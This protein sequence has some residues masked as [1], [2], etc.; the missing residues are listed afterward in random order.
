MAALAWLVFFGFAIPLA[1]TDARQHRLPNRIL[2]LAIPAGLLVLTLTVAVAGDWPALVPI[3]VGGAGTFL[4]LL[5]LALISR[6]A[7]G[8][9]DVKLGLFT[10]AYLGWI[11]WGAILW[12]TVLGLVLAGCYATVLLLLRRAHRQT[13]IPLGPFLL[14]AVAILGL[15]SERMLPCCA[16]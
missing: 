7:L 15:L 2:L 14:S 12:G 8:M 5:V 9:G 3:L 10:G 16:G 11:G 13:P 4:G 6:G 1:V